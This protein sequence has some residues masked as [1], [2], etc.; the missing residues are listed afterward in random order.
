MQELL[1]PF[2]NNLKD[3]SYSNKLLKCT[4]DIKK[5]IWNVMKNIIG[6]S[7][8]KLTNLPQKL[9]INKVDVYDK[10][11]IVDAFHDFF[12]NIGLKLASQIPESSKTFKTY[13]NKM[14]VIMESKPLSINELKD[15]FF[16]LKINKNLGV[17]DISSNIIKNTLGCFANP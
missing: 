12:T 16:S 11:E 13:I 8:T 7:N 3:S 2:R 4:G 6:K 10:P 15:A 9:T 17:D 14:N 5:N 1:E